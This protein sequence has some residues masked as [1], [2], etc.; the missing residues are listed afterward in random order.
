MIKKVKLIDDSHTASENQLT[1]LH[2]A[3]L[4]DVNIWS[5]GK[6]WERP[7]K[8]KKLEKEFGEMLTVKSVTA[9]ACSLVT[10]IE[11]SPLRAISCGSGVIN[12]YDHILKTVASFQVK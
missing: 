3:L 9:T 4:T 11:T 12:F 7:V 6:V 1:S 2:K 10:E 8:K 5:I